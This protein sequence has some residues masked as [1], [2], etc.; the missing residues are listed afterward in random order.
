MFKMISIA[1]VHPS[2]PFLKN[3][4]LSLLLSFPASPSLFLHV[5]HFPPSFNPTVMQEVMG[6]GNKE[7]KN[8]NSA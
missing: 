7:E 8:K 5:C 1:N 4:S 3:F 6:C 2:P